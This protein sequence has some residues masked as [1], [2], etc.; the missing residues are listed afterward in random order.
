LDKDGRN[1]LPQ[2]KRELLPG[3]TFRQRIDMPLW[4]VRV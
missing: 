3:E 4:Q 1:T 2:R